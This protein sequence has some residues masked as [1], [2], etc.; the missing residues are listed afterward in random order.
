MLYICILKEHP[1]LLNV[2]LLMAGSMI[3]TLLG[4]QERKVLCLS[5]EQ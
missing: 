2:H 5:K 1:E 3:L 4:F